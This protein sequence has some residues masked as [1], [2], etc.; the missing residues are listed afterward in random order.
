[1]LMTEQPDLDAYLADV[2]PTGPAGLPDVPSALP[3]LA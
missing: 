1:M 2:L 3:R